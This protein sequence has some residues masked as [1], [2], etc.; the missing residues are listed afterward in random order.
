MKNLF[1]LFFCLSVFCGYSQQAISDWQHEKE[2]SSDPRFFIKAGK[3]IYF[4]ASSQAKGEELWVT[5]GTTETTHFVKQISGDRN[6]ASF[7][8]T[9][10]PIIYTPFNPESWRDPYFFK[11]AVAL[12]NGTLYFV[13]TEYPTENPKIWITDGTEKGTKIFREEVKGNLFH[14]GNELVEYSIDGRNGKFNIYH[15]DSTKN[16]SLI[17]EKGQY[18][19]SNRLMGNLLRVSNSDNY[20]G[21]IDLKE[22]KI[23]VEAPIVPYISGYPDYFVEWNNDVYIARRPIKNTQ[24]LFG[25][26]STT[27]W[28]FDTLIVY[29]SKN[30]GYISSR[31]KPTSKELFFELGDSLFKIQNDKV[32]PVI[33]SKS[34]KEVF[35]LGRT[36]YDP[37]NNEMYAFEENESKK[38]FN[39]KSV[40]MSDGTLIR[41]FTIPN[42]KFLATI[43]PT[44]IWV[45]EYYLQPHNLSILDL[46]TQKIQE[47]PYVVNS[48]IENNNKMI[49]SGYSKKSKVNSELY[50]L[51]NQTD[52]VKLL[53]DINLNGYLKSA[54]FTTTFNT[55][56]VQ[57]YKHEK[58]I[59]LGISDGTKSGTKDVKLLIKNYDITALS[60][61]QFQSVNN[62]LG[63]LVTTRNSNQYGKDSIFL[64]SLNKQFNEI[65]TLIFDSGNA[66]TYEKP[67]S[68]LDSTIDVL[69]LKIY[70]NSTNGVSKEYITDLT[71]ENTKF[72]GNDVKYFV[73]VGKNVI[74]QNNPHE[75]YGSSSLLKYDLSNFTGTMI[76][77]SQKCR[78]IMTFDGKT[79]F[80]NPQNDTYYVTDGV[81]SNPLK[82]IKNIKEFIKIKNELF[83]IENPFLKT[84]FVENRYYVDYKYTLWQIENNTPKMILS[85]DSTSINGNVST[86]TKLWEINGKSF[87]LLNLFPKNYTDNNRTIFYEIGN[88]FSLKQVFRID[89]KIKYE[90]NS[91]IQFV[92]KG[93][94]FKQ[95]EG[96]K[97]VFYVMNSNFEPKEIY[98]TRDNEKVT[99][100]M[101]F[102]YSSKIYTFTSVGNVFVTDG[103]IEGSEILLENN[104]IN[105]YSDSYYTINQSVKTDM[106]K[107]YFS[108]S[109]LSVFGTNLWVTDGTK[110]GTIQLLQKNSPA[111]VPLYDGQVFSYASLGLI[112]N[113]YIF[114]MY[115]RDIEQYEVWITEGTVE[116][117][118][119][120]MDFKGNIVSRPYV[121][122]Y[123]QDKNYN[124]LEW[125][126]LPKINNKL[127]FSRQTSE[128]G[129]EPWETDGTPEGTKMMGDL[130][131]GVQ[132]SNPFQFVEIN[133]K[134]YVIATETNKALQL[135]SFCQPKA[136]FTVEKITQNSTEEVKLTA[137]QNN[138]YKYQWLKDKKEIDKANAV[139]YTATTSG[140][141]QL[142]VED[143]IGCTNVSDSLVI[144]FTQKILAN[145]PL[146]DTFGLKI[147]PNPTQNDLNLVFESN[148]RGNFEAMLYDVTGRILVQKSVNPNTNNIIPTQ[149]LN[150]G[151]YFLRLTNGEQQTIQK[152]IKN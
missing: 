113:K 119:K 131:N 60:D 41:D 11:N 19:S 149:S 23:K 8:L 93:I 143:L 138:E 87:L 96:L 24:I 72:L 53:K 47:F 7:P 75:F 97:T 135:W 150:A 133:Q 151:M 64:F 28:K 71:T 139:N 88:N 46:E 78:N 152:V 32:V 17:I 62:R 18:F 100:F 90:Q 73:N 103:S 65:K 10:A 52:E 146:T 129:Y 14:T 55:K 2:L 5:E 16:V 116:T 114:K 48:I 12:D 3:K 45:R 42:V 74:I 140:T 38:M 22:Q 130:V 124:I 115:N 102:G 145:E 49:F 1:T 80:Y 134:P 51:D 122:T 148:E 104:L 86:A 101:P 99:S 9:V 142:K 83:I 66:D 107:F 57:I 126:S 85:F 105:S 76:P 43:S 59:M 110:A 120:L 36:Q 125:I 58:G 33:N 30:N 25:K 21:I 39:V 123:Y 44:K 137:A 35:Y 37:V 54:V 141:Y 127:Y 34:Y 121:S 118:K 89:E 27:T 29:N 91:S 13:N 136:S 84:Y 15:Q 147:S 79:Y 111:N 109:P 56:L 70:Q 6:N 112:G 144:N 63:F 106:N 132:S 68:R 128:T 31:F 92:R 26:L 77:N 95:M 81:T 50:I 67:F 108:F 98:R 61:V 94:L 40:K 4:L 117:T 20:T 69:K 82:G